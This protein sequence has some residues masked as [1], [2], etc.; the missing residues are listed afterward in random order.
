MSYFK[1]MLSVVQ[2]IVL[3]F[4]KL[5]AYAWHIEILETSA[6]LMSTLNVEI[7]LPL[8]GRWWQMPSTVIPVY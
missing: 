1:R 2:N 5:L 8:D 7:V 4:C 6:S 3:P